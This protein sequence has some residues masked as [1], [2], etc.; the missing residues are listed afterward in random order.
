M[1]ET[2]PGAG[3]ALDKHIMLL[4]EELRLGTMV[5]SQLQQKAQPQAGA[6]N[7]T[8]FGGK[9]LWVPFVLLFR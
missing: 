9:T 2:V 1:P 8:H 5:Q 6:I 3:S 4:Q 7:W